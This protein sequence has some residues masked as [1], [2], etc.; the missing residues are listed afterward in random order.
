M[1]A[2]DVASPFASLLRSL[3]EREND[4]EQ[5]AAAC[6]VPRTLAHDDRTKAIVSTVQF[7]TR[8]RHE[9]ANEALTL[10]ACLVTVLR[11][12]GDTGPTADVPPTSFV[13]RI[14]ARLAM[15]TER[16][17]YADAS[18]RRRA[19]SSQANECSATSALADVATALGVENAY[20]DE[21]SVAVE[22]LKA[23]ERDQQVISSLVRSKRSYEIKERN[24]LATIESLSA[25]ATSAERRADALTR[26]VDWSDAT[27]ASITPDAAARYLASRGWRMTGQ[28]DDV[29]EWS[30]VASASGTTYSTRIYTRSKGPTISAEDLM[31]VAEVE[32]RRATLIVADMLTLST[33]GAR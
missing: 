31:R 27:L 25:R 2:A 6:G 32:T 23:I 21:D 10:R 11:A 3:V 24:A 9:W 18:A 30:R 8:S 5:I 17:A 26:A 1:S 15:L 28:N 19:Q 14:V 12:A 13:G 4:H 20:A 22:A 29:A 33:E 7:L 16:N